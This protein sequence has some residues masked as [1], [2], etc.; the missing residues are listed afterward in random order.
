[1]VM[2]AELSA[3]MGLVEPAFARRVEALIRRAG[4]PVRGPSSLS[5]DRYL[6][7]MRVDKKAEAGDIRFVLL[8]GVAHSTLRTAPEALV[9]DVIATFTAA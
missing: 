6:E 3:R 9:K 2:A 7:L 5:P 4:L 1:M 8:Y